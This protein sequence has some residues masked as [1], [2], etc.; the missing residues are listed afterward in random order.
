[1][2]HAS[3]NLGFLKLDKPVSHVLELILNFF[4]VHTFL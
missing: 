1:M 3:G 2:F 4:D